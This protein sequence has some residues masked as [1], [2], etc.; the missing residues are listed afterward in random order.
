MGD[1]GPA[2]MQDE[3]DQ[4]YAWIIREKAAYFILYLPHRQ[5]RHSALFEHILQRLSAVIR[6]LRARGIRFFFLGMDANETLPPGIETCTGVA[7][8]PR[9]NYRKE[10]RDRKDVLV[11]FLLENSFMV[12]TTYSCTKIGSELVTWQGPRGAAE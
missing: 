11:A 1:R 4:F 5:S 12:T 2:R 8:R 6:N 3:V 9:T 10:H 7:C